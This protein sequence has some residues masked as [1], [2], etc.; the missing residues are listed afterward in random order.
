MVHPK[1]FLFNHGPLL[2]APLQDKHSQYGHARKDDVAF[3]SSLVIY[4]TS[5][6][7]WQRVWDEMWCYWEHLGKH[8][9]T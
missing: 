3:S 5:V 4:V 2:V 7:F 8:M 6:K 9:G 1:R